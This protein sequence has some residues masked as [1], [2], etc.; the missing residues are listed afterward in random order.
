MTGD[1]SEASRVLSPDEAFSV[2]G[3][4]TRVRILQT[5]GEADA[6]LS[7]TELRDS[8]GIRQGAQ[9]NYHLDRVL[10]HFVRKTDDGYALRQPGRRVVQAIL[11]GAITD[12]SR[13]EPTTVD[14]A[15]RHC[16]TQV[17]VSYRD[18]EMGLTCTEC[19]GNYL[20][21]A[22]QG[23]EDELRWNLSR[24]SLPP[25]G[26]RGRSPLGVLRAAATLEHLDALA[27]ASD[28]CPR[29][30][31][32]VE[33]SL[34]ACKDHEGTDGVCDRCEAY[35][36]V[37]VHYRCTNCIYE[38]RFAAVMGILDAPP[39]LAFLGDHGHNPSAGGIEW[40][41]EY[42]EE[43]LSTDPFSARFTFTIDGDT[44]TL[45]VDEAFRVESVER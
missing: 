31:A 5:L 21:T 30:S 29:C 7:F 11:S 1:D 32:S 6:A 34:H 12:D 18:G 28:V 35:H 24:M 9:F 37:H 15:C 42:D 39:L 23:E 10:G 38:Q 3:N 8:V 26:V 17:D 16:G 4:E 13:V 43:I 19:S 40:G 2:L 45:V 25:A 41:W 36:A 27:A 33:Q 14:F 22:G 20:G 44:I